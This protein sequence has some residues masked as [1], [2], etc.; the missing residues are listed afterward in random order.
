[1]AH[2][3]SIIC[4]F[5]RLRRRAPFLYDFGA[6]ESM[7]LFIVRSLRRCLSWL[8]SYCRREI[9][10]FTDGIARRP[11]YMVKGRGRGG[12][13]VPCVVA[14]QWYVRGQNRQILN[15]IME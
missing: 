8:R 3:S 13:V 15:P 11:R 9:S 1:M 2:L 10:G 12:A 5:F 6:P 4:S 7:E 14:R